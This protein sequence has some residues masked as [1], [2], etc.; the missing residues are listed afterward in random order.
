MKGKPKVVSI[1]GAR[2]QFIKLAPLVGELRRRFDHTLIHT[3]QHY[4]ENMSDVFFRQLRI[5]RADINL[6]IGGGAHG[7]MTGRMLATIEKN[8]SDLDPAFVLVFGDTNTTMAGALAATKMAIPVG[9]IE[10]GMRSF[11]KYMPEE[12]NRRVTDHVSDLLFCPTAVAMNH[13]KAEN[14]PGR[15]IRSGDL[16]YELLHH[17]R[18]TIKA[19]RRLLKR[20]KLTAGEYVLITLHRAANV[21]CE[22]NLSQAVSLL[23]AMPLPTLFPIHPRTRKRLRQFKLWS[24]LQKAAN[25]ITCDPLGYLDTLSA[26]CHAHMVMTDSG[27]L[28]KEA[29][30]LGTPVLTLREETEWVE[31]LRRGNRLVGLDIDRILRLL[32]SRL[33]ARPAPYRV[34]GRKPSQI[35][36]NEITRFLKER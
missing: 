30:F 3:G 11:V 1:V 8:L 27:G 15:V 12:I 24:R 23:E 16:M 19:N 13:L 26:A 31:T 14:V 17:S 5:P 22:E 32:R 18:A 34:G 6:H 21:D 29:L 36:G 28:Q 9:H 33:K 35:I 20:L 25:V 10:A 7:A 4:D 2:P